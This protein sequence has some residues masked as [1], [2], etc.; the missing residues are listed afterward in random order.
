MVKVV[1]TRKN[2][3]LINDEWSGKIRKD[4]RGYY[5]TEVVCERCYVPLQADTKHGLRECVERLFDSTY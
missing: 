4:H 5:V 1:F 2:D 3:I